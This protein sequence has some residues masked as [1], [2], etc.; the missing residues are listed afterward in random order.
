M[1]RKRICA[2]GKTSRSKTEALLLA[3]HQKFKISRQLS[4]AKTCSEKN[5]LYPLAGSLWFFP[6]KLRKPWTVT[7]LGWENILAPEDKSARVHVPR[8]PR[9]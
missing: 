2:L 4:L 7:A 9:P 6:K 5:L 1:G 3:S 8:S